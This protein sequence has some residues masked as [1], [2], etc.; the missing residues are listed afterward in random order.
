MAT[1]F[2]DVTDLPPPPSSLYHCEG[3]TACT[4]E[5]LL[6]NS[7]IMCKSYGIKVNFTDT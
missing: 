1:M 2:G 4:L 7:V 5:M 3:M 6:T